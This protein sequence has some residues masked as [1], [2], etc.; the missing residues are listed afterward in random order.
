MRKKGGKD[1]AVPSL[2]ESDPPAIACQPTCRMYCVYWQWRAGV[3]AGAFRK[4]WARL[5]QKIYN[6]DPLVCAK[7]QGKM[8]IISFI[9]DGEII[10]KILRHLDLWDTRN[11]DPPAHRIPSFH[12]YTID[13][14]CLSG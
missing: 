5:I 3:S 12:D 7:C 6:V 14:S 11:H 10:E 9:E 1:D 13:H 2:I 4:N 8:H